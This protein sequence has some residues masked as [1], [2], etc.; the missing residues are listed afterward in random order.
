LLGA[1]AAAVRPKPLAA[2][3]GENENIKIGM[4]H[5]M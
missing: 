4:H 3:A 1:R 2:A 5:T